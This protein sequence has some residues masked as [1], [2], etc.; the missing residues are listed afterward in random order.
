MLLQS[1]GIG[2]DTSSLPGYRL[3]ETMPPELGERVGFDILVCVFVANRAAVAATP[4]ATQLPGF[5]ESKIT[6][7]KSASSIC[8]PHRACVSSQLDLTISAAS[9][10][11]DNL[12]ASL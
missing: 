11:F 12:M 3:R 9:P 7:L 10:R 1:D 8:P 2:T 6:W 5:E 4:F